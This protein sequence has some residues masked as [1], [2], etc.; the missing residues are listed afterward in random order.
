[1]EWYSDAWTQEQQTVTVSAGAGITEIQQVETTAD[2][3]NIAGAFRLR[4]MGQTT[5][6]IAHDASAAD[7]KMS[8]QRLSTIGAVAIAD[9][10]ESKKPL[11]GSV[12][13]ANAASVLYASGD[14]SRH[15]TVAEVTQALASGSVG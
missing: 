14:W 2:L 13:I 4:F 12:W 3:N 5:E 6:D 11:S 1:M 7:M 8:L 15:F 9:R 10:T